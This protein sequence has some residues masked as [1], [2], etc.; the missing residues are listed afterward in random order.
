MSEY[1]DRLAQQATELNLERESLIARRSRILND[2]HIISVR[3]ETLDKAL[4]ENY[5][6][7]IPYWPGCRQPESELTFTSDIVKSY[8]GNPERSQAE[9]AEDLGVSLHVVSG[10]LDTHFK[11]ILAN[12]K[13][14]Q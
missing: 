12:L 1:Y 8:Y 7:Q 9:L 14:G 11:Q 10:T 3:M 13:H 2:L 5:N 6:E 4:E